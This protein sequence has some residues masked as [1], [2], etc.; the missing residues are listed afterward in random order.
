VKILCRK[1]DFTYDHCSPSKFF[2]QVTINASNKPED[3]T[4]INQKF[5]ALQASAQ[6]DGDTADLFTLNKVPFDPSARKI[7]DKYA[8]YSAVVTPKDNKEAL[9][10][11]VI[12]AAIALSHVLRVPVTIKLPGADYT[13]INVQDP[14][15]YTAKHFVGLDKNS[16]P[17][18]KTARTLTLGDLKKASLS[19]A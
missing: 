3:E 18:K 6:K 19:P 11:D 4:W 15:G 5:T 16:R 14:M 8:L 10:H 9:V 7:Y 17:D 2:G 13:V 1:P 12:S